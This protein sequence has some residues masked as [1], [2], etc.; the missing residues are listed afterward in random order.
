MNKQKGFTLVE[1]IGVVTVLALILVVAVPSLTKTLK[2]NEQNK[3]ND[4]I[5]NLKIAAE[6]YVVGK[7]KEGQFFEDGKDYNYISLGDLIDAGYIKNT[8]TNPENDKT[9]SRDSRVKVYKEADNTF[10]YDVQEYYN[11]ASDY[12]KNNL[13]IHYDAVEY[14]P[15]NIFKNLTGEIDYN[16]SNNATWTEDGVYFDKNKTSNAI[17]KLNNNYNTEEITV[18]FNIESLDALGNTSDDYTYPLTLFDESLNYRK[19]DLGLRAYVYLFYYSG[20]NTVIAM[21]TTMEK[22]KTYTLTYV[23]EDLTTRKLY[24]NGELLQTKSELSLE[25]IDYSGILISPRKYN[26]NLNNMLIYN[27]ALSAQE[28]QEL[29]ALDKDRFG[30]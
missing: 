17:R 15:N 13:I 18:S 19:L 26:L 6:N 10:S 7:L 24:L 25:T 2:R 5:D 8:T 4:Y 11:N 20:N 21:G 22:N 30:E 9:L 29:Y 23:Q 12:D 28:V 16:Y 1:V 3:Y 14:S 27:R